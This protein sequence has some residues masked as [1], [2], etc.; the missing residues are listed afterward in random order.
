MQIRYLIVILVA[1]SECVHHLL[2]KTKHPLST[3]EV[4]EPYLLCLCCTLF[5]SLGLHQYCPAHP[6]RDI[7]VAE[8]R[9]L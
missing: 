9:S 6:L 2:C 4:A 8:I 7:F 3:F 1:I 5:V